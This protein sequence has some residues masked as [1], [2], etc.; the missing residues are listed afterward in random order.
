MSGIL[1]EKPVGTEVY[2]AA[3]SGAT[4]SGTGATSSGAA[5][6]SPT[7]AIAWGS[8][9]SDTEISVFFA[10]NR[11]YVVRDGGVTY[12][13][14]GW[15]DYEIGQVTLAFRLIESVTNVTFTRVDGF[16][17]ADFVLGLDADE[18]M[19]PHRLGFFN[20]PGVPG[21]GRGMF[22]GTAWD[23]TPGG[24]LERG[25]VGFATIVHE[26]LHGL[27]LAHPHDLGGE[28]SVMSG[29]TGAFDDYGLYDL[30]QGVFTAM[31]YNEGIHTGTIGRAPG[32][33]GDW[34]AEAGPMALDIAVLQSLYGANMSH[35]TGDDVYDLPGLNGTGTFWAAIWDAGG[36]DTIRYG[37][38]LDAVIDLRP[39]TL[40]Y[41]EG[42]GGFISAVDDIAGGFTI[43]NG[44]EIE[45]AISG[46]GNDLIIGNGGDNVIL[47]RAGNDGVSAGM[48]DDIV[49]GGSGHDRL[50]GQGG[51]DVLIGEDGDD[52]LR[53]HDGADRL[54]SG[55]GDDFAAGGAGDDRII[56]HS[57]SDQV[58]AGGGNDRILTGPGND[59]VNAG[60][61]DDIVELG[62]GRDRFVFREG[63]GSDLIRDFDPRSD[64]LILDP[65]LIP[66][67]SG[68]RDILSVAHRTDHGLALVFDSGDSIMLHGV[69]N[70]GALIDAFHCAPHLA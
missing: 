5:S 59:L 1:A 36:Y 19:A 18:Q 32:A 21:Y 14:E 20:P 49:R 57:G 12:F 56:T 55:K 61:G 33:D 8:S 47:A 17:D 25:G 54:R 4:D 62:A 60:T 35:A 53:G 51:D 65:G 40:T 9:V 70:A 63:D 68:P 23:R 10:E 28:S 43:A 6:G 15:N 46:R 24:D 26:L 3:T 29:V 42:G 39:A 2:A 13:S 44:V 41:G 52:D 48:G 16:F 67:Y 11:D 22:N 34:G 7:D 45:R 50:R 27:G 38:V 64:R 37:G 30:N 58:I 31:S 69:M 66:D